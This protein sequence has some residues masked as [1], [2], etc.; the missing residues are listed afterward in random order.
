MADRFGR[1]DLAAEAKSPKSKYRDRDPG[2][3]GSPRGHM[4]AAAA[5]HSRDYVDI[6]TGRRQHHVSRPVSLEEYAG[7]VGVARA[8]Q[9][10]G[11]VAQRTSPT[12]PAAGHG[13]AGGTGGG[14]VAVEMT[15][16]DSPTNERPGMAL[17]GGT[18]GGSPAGEGGRMVARPNPAAGGEGG[19]GVVLE[20]PSGGFPG[21]KKDR[22]FGGPIPIRWRFGL[23]ARTVVALMVLITSFTVW[24]ALVFAH[25]LSP[26]WSNYGPPP[27]SAPLNVSF[28]SLG[29][30]TLNARGAFSPDR[31]SFPGFEGQVGHRH[32]N[33]GCPTPMYV[34]KEDAF[35]A[36]LLCPLMVPLRLGVM[37]EGEV[38]SAAAVAWR[39]ASPETF[40]PRV[41]T[42]TEVITTLD[43]I[44]SIERPF[45]NV[46]PG[47]PPSPLFLSLPSFVCLPAKTLS[48]LLFSL[49]PPGI[50]YPGFSGSVWFANTAAVLLAIANLWFLSLLECSLLLTLGS[51]RRVVLF[52]V[53]AWILML[54]VRC[55]LGFLFSRA[56]GW[57]AP[58]FFFS[59]S[60]HECARGIFPF[61]SSLFSTSLGGCSH[62]ESVL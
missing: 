42:R 13:G 3:R 24:D 17:G 46:T 52:S 29:T 34:L 28:P 37:S 7:N 16:D 48:L 25:P 12:P 31:S 1:K 55:G 43:S 10:S 56:V 30:S 26:G 36:Y 61:F 53:A 15:E 49:S 39:A 6:E 59:D 9:Y 18:Q 41:R 27:A 38:D 45:P 44:I 35:L 47:R 4:V 11:K 8:P 32:E 33:Y 60:M 22:M 58:A 14:F 57:Y 62:A 54:A 50:E 51:Q 21:R 2:P 40:R 20:M 5:G 23:M 19:P